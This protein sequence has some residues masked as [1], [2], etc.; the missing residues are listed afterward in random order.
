MIMMVLCRHD[1]LGC[2]VGANCANFSLFSMWRSVVLPAL[3]RPRNKILPDLPPRPSQFRKSQNQS[4]RPIVRVCVCDVKF[5]C[6]FVDNFV[7]LL[8]L[9]R[10]HHINCFFVERTQRR[11]HY[12]SHYSM[13][14][15]QLHRMRI[16]EQWDIGAILVRTLN[17]STNRQTH[18]LFKPTRN[19]TVTKM[20]RYK[21]IKI[22]GDG[23]F[24]SVV[25]AVNQETGE[26]VSCHFCH[27]WR[28]H[29]IL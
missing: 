4:N 23:T 22:I 28:S 19:S 14:S 3:S 1:V 21:V 6:V 24:G 16:F 29:L 25:K 12:P 27:A 8:S 9:P 20:N 13:N 26:L 15:I 17:K 7:F 11:S 18:K 2:M 10:V 5:C